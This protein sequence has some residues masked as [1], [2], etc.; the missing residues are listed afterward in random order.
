MRDE[1][2]RMEHPHRLE[3]RSRQVA[4]LG[5]L[6]PDTA[7]RWALRSNDGI[8]EASRRVF[9]DLDIL[10]TAVTPQLPP[11]IPKLHHLGTLASQVRSTTAVAFTGY[12]N[13][14][15]N[16]A[17]SVPVG[18]TAEGLPLAVQ[19]IG[20]HG[21]DRLVL[22]VARRLATQLTPVDRGARP[23]EGTS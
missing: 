15:G 19:V 23:R 3:R 7:L 13:M 9:N 14:A 21:R 8:E 20:G 18:V 17:A 6:L 22:A 1:A 10:L 4:R 5:R 11:P 16:P 12:W 2:E